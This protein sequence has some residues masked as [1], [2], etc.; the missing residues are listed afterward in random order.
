MK[1][2]EQNNQAIMIILWQADD[3]PNKTNADYGFINRIRPAVLQNKLAYVN[4]ILRKNR[5]SH[6][7]TTIK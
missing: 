7:F 2:A 1:L 6:D 3:N 5:L 4:F